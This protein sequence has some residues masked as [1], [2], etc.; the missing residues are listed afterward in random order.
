[1]KKWIWAAGL[2]GL[3]LCV[4]LG[5]CTDQPTASSSSNSLVA[6]GLEEEVEEEW[7]TSSAEAIDN[8]AYRAALDGIAGY[9]EGTAGSSLKLAIVAANLLNFT[10]EYRP[11]QAEALK[12][13]TKAYLDS[14]EEDKK[15]AFEK[16]LSAMDA[17]AREILA[18]GEQIAGLL[19]DAGN[20]Q[21]YET[22]N[23]DRYAAVLGIIQDAL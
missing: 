21:H 1:M 9:E 20:P 3:L 5:G 8:A 17:T 6:S 13:E 11:D 4:V 15:A 23:P 22:Y 19:E 12:E 14:L 7:E 16:N 2:A 18:G 10:E